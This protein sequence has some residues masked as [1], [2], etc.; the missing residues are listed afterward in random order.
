MSTRAALTAVDASAG[1]PSLQA[2]LDAFLAQPDL[3]ASTRR[4]YAQ[5][6]GRLT[7]TLGPDRA[8]VELEPGE[9]PQAAHAAWGAAA[10]ATW[11]RH[12]ATLRSFARYCVRARLAGSRG[13]A[14]SPP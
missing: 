4:S 7:G 3:A 10:P 6:L 2:A 1:G 14:C 9:L 8:L 11:N 5:T 13:G 12:V